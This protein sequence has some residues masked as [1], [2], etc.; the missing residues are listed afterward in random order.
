[1]KFKVG[2]VCEIVNGCCISS[3]SMFAGRECTITDRASRAGFGCKCG[4]RTYDYFRV[5]HSSSVGVPCHDGCHYVPTEYLRLKRPPSWDS[6]LYDTS[7]VKDETPSKIEIVN[8]ALLR[9]GSIQ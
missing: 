8:D 3:Q 2:D 1:M 9:I 5:E 4:Y 7:K 6:W